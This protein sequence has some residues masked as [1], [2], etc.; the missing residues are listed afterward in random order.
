MALV[1]PSSVVLDKKYCIPWDG[2][3][4]VNSD[5]FPGSWFENFVFSDLFLVYRCIVR[6]VEI[7]WTSRVKGFASIWCRD[8]CN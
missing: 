3:G 2:R 6:R 1:L 5:Y 7:N 4:G 8:T